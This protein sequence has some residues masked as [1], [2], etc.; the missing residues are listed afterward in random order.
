MTRSPVVFVTGFRSLFYFF[1]YWNM[2]PLFLREHG[3]EVQVWNLPWK[4]SAEQLRILQMSLRQAPRPVHLFLDSSNEDLQ[5]VLLS[6][7]PH[8]TSLTSTKD[9]SLPSVEPASWRDWVGG[10]IFKTHLFYQKIRTPLRAT[11][12]ENE[13]GLYEGAISWQIENIY[14]NHIIRLAEEELANRGV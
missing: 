5:K 6:D 13:L 9:L 4:D 10:V 7:G 2:I 8:I 11:P 1:S 3:Y 14:L 12:N